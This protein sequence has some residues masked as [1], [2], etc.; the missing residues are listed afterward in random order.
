METFW[1]KFWCYFDWEGTTGASNLND[2]DDDTECFSDI[3]KR[4]G[5]G[6]DNIGKY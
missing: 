3:P 2:Q 5:Q 1:E 4:N 6:I